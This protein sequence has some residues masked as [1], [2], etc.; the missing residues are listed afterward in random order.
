[1]DL[2]PPIIG[3]TRAGHVRVPRGSA[4]A[5]AQAPLINILLRGPSLS[6]TVHRPALRG[7]SRWFLPRSACPNDSAWARM[8][9]DGTDGL[10]LHCPPLELS[11]CSCLSCACLSY[12][13]S[14]SCACLSASASCTTYCEVSK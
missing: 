4:L 1:V 6:P 5:G 3:A 10:G 11:S 13:C 8:V 2:P 7:A 9:T 12:S 14:C